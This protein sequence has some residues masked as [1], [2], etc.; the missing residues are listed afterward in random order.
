MADTVWLLFVQMAQ[1]AAALESQRK[2]SY[3]ILDQHLKQQVESGSVDVEAAL[4]YANSPALQG[5]LGGE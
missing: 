4:R 2:N 5:Y 3:P 1:I